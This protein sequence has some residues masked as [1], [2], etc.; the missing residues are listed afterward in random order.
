MFVSSAREEL[1][2]YAS[3]YGRWH[4]GIDLHNTVIKANSNTNIDMQE[5]VYGIFSDRNV[6][7][8]YAVQMN[9]LI[10]WIIHHHVFHFVQHTSLTFISLQVCFKGNVLLGKE[11]I[12]QM[13]VEGK[14][15][16]RFMVG[17][18]VKLVNKS[19]IL[20]DLKCSLSHHLNDEV[21]VKSITIAWCWSLKGF[22]P[23]SLLSTDEDHQ[24]HY[25][26]ER[27]MEKRRERKGKRKG[28]RRSKRV[29]RKKTLADKDG[30]CRR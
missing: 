21:V 5:N 19:I 8:R 13:T 27:R 2:R 14:N 11:E 15:C 10:S 9:L 17:F 24:D 22:K 20:E 25:K 4:I 1:L 7:G 23:S 3:P 12:L 26:K 18:L 29:K 30:E 28:K 16:T 6:W